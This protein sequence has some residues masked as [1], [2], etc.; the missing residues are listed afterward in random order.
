MSKYTIYL[1]NISLT[2]ILQEEVEE[3]DQDQF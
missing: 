2:L 3:K 1:G